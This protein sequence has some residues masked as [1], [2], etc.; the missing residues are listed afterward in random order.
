MRMSRTPHTCAIL[1]EHTQYTMSMRQTPRVCAIL[2]EHTPYS[3]RMR[4]TLRAC[5]VLR[6]HAPYFMRIRRI[7]CVCSIRMRHTSC[8]RAMLHAHVRIP[9]DHLNHQKFSCILHQKLEIEII[10]LKSFLWRSK[11]TFGNRFFGNRNPCLEVEIVSVEIMEIKM[12][13]DATIYIGHHA[14]RNNDIYK[15]R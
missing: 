5:S 9:F 2:H 7:Q 11:S 8:S 13:G 10:F 4:H 14:T 1:H 15:Y 6:A 12:T 3:M